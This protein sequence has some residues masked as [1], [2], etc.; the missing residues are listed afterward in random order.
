MKIFFGEL[1]RKPKAQKISGI[2]PLP[3]AKVKLG[4][5]VVKTLER[6][7]ELNNID[8][9]DFIRQARGTGQVETNEGKEKYSQ[10]Y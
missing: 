3:K 5:A 8:I 2:A 9:E 10:C 6:N 4:T 7:E 1:E